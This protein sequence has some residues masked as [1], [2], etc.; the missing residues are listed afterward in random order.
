MKPQDPAKKHAKK[1]GKGTNQPYDN[2]ILVQGYGRMSKAHADKHFPGFP[3]HKISEA[4]EQTITMTIPLFIR[5]LEWAKESA[6]DDIALHKFT[7][8]AI[9]KSVNGALTISDYDNLIPKGEKK[10]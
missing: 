7:E 4:P 9:D 3:Q 8:L 10:E 5:C 2:S 1:P 6:S